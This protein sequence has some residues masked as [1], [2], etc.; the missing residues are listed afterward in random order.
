MSKIKIIFFLLS[1]LPQG[2]FCFTCTISTPSLMFP[3]YD[4]SQA[5]PATTAGT[6]SVSCDDNRKFD[7]TVS[8]SAGDSGSFFPRVMNLNGVLGGPSIAYNLYYGSYPPAGTIWGDGTPGAPPSTVVDAQC[9]VSPCTQTVYG[10]IFPLQNV[11]LGL[12]TANIVVQM[13]YNH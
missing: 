6:I 12:Y 9:H 11:S 7:Y 8:L 13:T 3:D 4:A 10:T 5:S 2:A 1:F